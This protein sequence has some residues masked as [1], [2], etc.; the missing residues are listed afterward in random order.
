MKA[1]AALQPILGATKSCMK[2]ITGNLRT[3]QQDALICQ[4]MANEFRL[5]AVESS[6]TVLKHLHEWID[7]VRQCQ[8]SIWVRVLISISQPVCFRQDEPA[9]DNDLDRYISQLLSQIKNL[10]GE[11]KWE[12]DE[13]QHS[14]EKK[15]AAAKTHSTDQMN[16][17]ETNLR[18]AEDRLLQKQELQNMLKKKLAQAEQLKAT[19][20]GAESGEETLSCTAHC[21]LILISLHVHFVLVALFVVELSLSS[22]R[23]AGEGTSSGQTRS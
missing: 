8:F 7:K 22:I 15:V 6:E 23:T 2:D 20:L 4:K 13:V 11:I 21:C 5:L 3:L 16:R 18:E 9:A 14:Q 19:G 10:D 1:L 17:A 12:K